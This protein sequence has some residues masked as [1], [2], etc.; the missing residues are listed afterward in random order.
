MLYAF[1][2]S[3]VAGDQDENSV[4]QTTCWGNELERVRY[5]ISFISHV[6]KFLNVPLKNC[7]IP[8]SGNIP[9]LDILT[10][11]VLSGQIK[12]GDKIFFG[13][14]TFYRDRAALDP[15]RILNPNRGPCF[16]DREI[17]RN[18]RLLIEYFDYCYI[19]S[20]LEKIKN[21]YEID[22]RC[23]NLVD[24]TYYR[25]VFPQYKDFHNSFSDNKF[26]ITCDYPYNNTLIHILTDTWGTPD[27]VFHLQ[28]ANHEVVNIPLE[29][30]HLFTPHWHPSI[31]GH[32]KIAKWLIDNV[33]SEN[34]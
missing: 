26:F 18:N 31:E 16:A 12:K 9:Q 27:C 7:A 25:H 24:K 21:L 1:G 30:A 10:E 23:I 14:T 2:D 17:F 32:K 6:A 3:F 11:K 13:F 34:I 22:I 19:L 8:G 5:E 33:Y 20:I 29:C 28:H 4:L 15:V